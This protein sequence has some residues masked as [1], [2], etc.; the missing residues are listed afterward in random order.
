V[1]LE[2]NKEIKDDLGANLDSIRELQ[3]TRAEMRP[4]K[5]ITHATIPIDKNLGKKSKFDGSQY[6]V[7]GYSLRAAEEIMKT[8]LEDQFT[9]QT[10]SNVEEVLMKNYIETKLKERFGNQ[11]SKA[12]ENKTSGDS[13][14]SESNSSGEKRTQP[15]ILEGPISHLFKRPKSEP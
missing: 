11:G 1:N 10:D 8:S 12:S 3:K 6:R 9:A 13:A 4:S 15:D 2:E 14:D 7:N 5:G